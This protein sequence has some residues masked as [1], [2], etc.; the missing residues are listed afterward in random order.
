[1]IRAR[2]LWVAQLT[3]VRDRLGHRTAW[4]AQ[5]FEGPICAVLIFV[6]NA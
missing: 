4:L 6:K 5:T 3:G 1:M 2:K